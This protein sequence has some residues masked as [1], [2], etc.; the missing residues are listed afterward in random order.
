[1]RYQGGKC[2]IAKPIMTEILKYRTDEDTFV[3]LFVGGGCCGY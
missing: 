2:R 3:D 1:M